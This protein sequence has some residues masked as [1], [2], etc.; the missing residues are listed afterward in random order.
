M[1]FFSILIFSIITIDSFSQSVAEAFR[2]VNS[3]EQAS[4]F[5][6]KYPEAEARLFSISS[7]KDTSDI[8]VPLFGK[9]AGYV[10]SL[11]QNT[12]KIV[13]AQDV[14]LYRVSYI[15]FD[16]NLLDKTLIDSFRTLVMEKFRQGTSFAKLAKEYTMDF[17][18]TGDLNW[19]TTGEMVAEFEDAV[20]K[21][22]QF[23]LFTVDIPS[24]NWYHVV[25]KTFDDRIIKKLTIL[26]IRKLE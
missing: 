13:E 12:F 10:F 16:G 25:L 21:H 26:K 19:F 3:L 17:N 6:I 11:E 9:K 20:K 14:P 7:D 23:D 5:I 4:D 8:T 18:P 24:K 2:T 1:K 15:F 22:K